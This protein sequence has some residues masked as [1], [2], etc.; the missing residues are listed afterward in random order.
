VISQV[1]VPDPASVG[2][3]VA[4]AAQAMAARGYDVRVLSSARGYEDGNEKYARRER[5]AGVDVRRLAFSSFGKRSLAHRL[6]GQGI[7]LLQVIMRSLFARRLAGILVS[8]SPPMASFAAVVISFV[9]RVPITY[10]LMDMNPDQALALGKVSPRS[11]L[12]WAMRWLNR[13]I[14]VRAAS[15]VVLDRFMAER[16][17]RQY[18]VR[19]RLEILPPWPHVA[20]MQDKETRPAASS[21]ERRQGDKESE[22]CGRVS[23][24][25]PLPLSPS[26]SNSLRIEAQTSNPFVAEHNL[27]GR[28]VVMYSGNHSLA[29][30]VTTLV[31]TALR[32]RDDPRFIFVFVGGGIGKR[33]VERAIHAHKPSNILSLPY[34]PLERLH[35]SLS[36][37]DVHVVTLG[38]DMVGI[39]HPCKIYGAMAVGRPVLLIGPRPS[40]AADIIERHEIGWRIDHGDVE[41]L[42]ALLGRISALPPAELAAMGQR[43]REAVIQHYS[44]ARLCSD[45]CD[46]VE[47]GIKPL[48]R[49]EPARP[50]LAQAESLRQS[51]PWKAQH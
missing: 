45:F 26:I 29:S 36:A 46:I 41:G 25:P 8:T 14:F 38:E 49:G 13:R 51:A 50:H 7:F 1:Y 31:E 22:L 39:I 44:K 32:M 23:L 43:A 17:E 6:L 40:H 47:R 12:V 18:D 35:F 33:V 28:V 27:A 11:P 37:A 15:V 4:D 20:A 5:R 21:A 3:H 10:W 2:Q 24:S 42:A 19:G 48:E 34:Q 16:V 9:R 30:P